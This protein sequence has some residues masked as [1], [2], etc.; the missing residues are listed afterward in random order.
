MKSKLSIVLSFTLGIA[1]DSC[2][3]HIE[4]PAEHSYP[5]LSSALVISESEALNISAKLLNKET[6][7]RNELDDNTIDYITS[8]E[9]SRT[10]PDTIAYVIN[11]ENNNG[12]TVISKK[13]IGNPVLAYSKT[14]AIDIENEAI[15]DCF[16]SNIN[17]YIEHQNTSDSIYLIEADPKCVIIEPSSD[18]SLT[19][20]A[21]YNKTVDKYYPGCPVG[22]VPLAVVN[23]MLHC[24]KSIVCFDKFYD[25]Q[26]ILKALNGSID[27]DGAAPQGLIIWPP[28]EYT[29][30]T[31]IGHVADLLYNIGK[32]VHATYTTDGT[33]AKSDS[34]FIFLTDIGYQI[35]IYTKNCNAGQ[36]GY[37]LASDYL[38]YFEGQDWG[39]KNAHAW[40]GDGVT[41]CYGDDNR[42]LNENLKNVYIHCDWG[43]GG[44]S[45]G[46]YTGNIFSPNESSDFTLYK[47]FAVKIER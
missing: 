12:F 19:Q 33:G 42:I 31:A 7:S 44:S 2:T 3:E 37:H 5:N 35:D 34:A 30:E 43:W 27:S 38:I 1:V 24:K 47:Y 39:H 22:C 36:I 16:I 23:L 4:L 32:E 18:I 15:R 10:Y 28:R 41:F 20:W 9:Y 6:N 45:N 25:C 11:Y 13:R 17:S 40:V 26:K 14:G 29:R 21:P 8:T 46:W